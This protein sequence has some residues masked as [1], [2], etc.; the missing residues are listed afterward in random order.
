MNR[1]AFLQKRHPLRSTRTT[2]R[3]IR[4]HLFGEST[5]HD[6]HR[7][8]TLHHRT[9][10]PLAA[11]PHTASP[12]NSS[13]SWRAAGA[14]LVFLALGLPGDWAPATFTPDRLTADGSFL[15]IAWSSCSSQK[16]W[17]GK[18]SIANAL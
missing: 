13:P 7:T 4:T 18:A 9:A 16:K 15:A 3:S 17:I 5:A 14:C 8:F 12:P 1:G 6:S 10:E 11:N 2:E